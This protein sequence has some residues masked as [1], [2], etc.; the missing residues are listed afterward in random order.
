MAAGAWVDVA[1]AAAMLA[2]VA[3]TLASSASAG[4]DTAPHV[5]VW[6]GAAGVLI[7]ARLVSR[8]G[9]RIP[10]AI[11]VVIA[12][13]VLLRAPASVMSAAP[14]AGPFGY[15]SITGA[16][17]AQAAIAGLM[18]ATSR[19]L[20]VRFGGIVAAGAFAW[21]TITT[22]TRTAMLLVGLVAVATI[23][24]V[25]FRSARGA[26]VM[27][28]LMLAVAVA[29]TVGLGATFERDR[30][31][32]EARIVDASVTERR[33]A[34]WHDAIVLTARNPLF[35]VGPGRFAFESPVARSDQDEPWVHEE[36]LQVSSESGI[37]AGA[38]LV[39][40]FGLGFARLAVRRPVDALA[41]LASA[42]LAVLGVHACVEYVL[43]RP[44]VPLAAAALV[45]AG[46]GPFGWME[47]R[48]GRHA[49]A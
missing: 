49:G 23:V 46:I 24:A 35:G 42:S 8:A 3:W 17:F 20:A 44:A 33:Q 21:V 15:S 11:V 31:T 39:A 48:R 27:F 36:F 9:R 26:V 19:T 41:V 38:L 6:L 25:A 43:Q 47:R 18:L 7:A 16:F 45:G 28:G 30:S 32:L 5:A 1:W 4:T 2:L 22:Q 34:L 40:V 29:A 14:R 10:P 13:A 12:A 37:A